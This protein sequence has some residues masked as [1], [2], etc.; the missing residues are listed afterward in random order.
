MATFLHAHL[1]G[2]V[3]LFLVLAEQN[4]F[5]GSDWLGRNIVRDLD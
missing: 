4:G 5:A 3:Q 1:P 2:L